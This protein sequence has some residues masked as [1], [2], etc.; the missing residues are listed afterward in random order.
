MV[1]AGLPEPRVDHVE[2]A[3]MALDMLAETRR[4]GQGLGLDLSIRIGMDTGPVIVGVIARQKFLYDLWDDT[5]NTA[6]RMES[7]VTCR[8]GS[9]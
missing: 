9:R 6:S 5:V 7:H 2:A 4:G 8:G 1:V 3:A